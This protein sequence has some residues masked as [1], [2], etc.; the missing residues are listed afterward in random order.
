MEVDRRMYGGGN[1]TFFVPPPKKKIHYYITIRLPPI[2]DRL[3]YGTLLT[4]G[5]Q[6]TPSQY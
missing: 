1:I 2:M 4:F 5:H 3:L 6:S